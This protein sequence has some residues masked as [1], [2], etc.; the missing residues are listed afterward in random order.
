MVDF[1]PYVV[2]IPI[3]TYHSKALNRALENTSFKQVH[4]LYDQTGAPR[5]G[6]E[7]VFKRYTLLVVEE[8]A[9]LQVFQSLEY[10]EYIYIEPLDGRRFECLLR[11]EPY[12]G[13]HVFM[14]LSTG[15]NIG[16]MA[17]PLILDYAVEHRARF[18]RLYK[19]IRSPEFILCKRQ[20]RGMVRFMIIARRYREDFYK[21]GQGKF[22]LAAKQRFYKRARLF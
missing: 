22:E 10:K 1:P 20:L 8:R 3:K 13:D 15:K 11:L 16:K 17:L 12:Y 21:P 5:P 19:W 9:K 6:T 14:D 4:E 7:D 18:E 2:R